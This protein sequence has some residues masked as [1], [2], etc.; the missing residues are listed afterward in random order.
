MK[1]GMIIFV[2]LFL[3]FSVFLGTSQ[4]ASKEFIVGCNL[5]LSGPAASI[6][7]GVQRAMDHAVEVINKDGF[8]VQGEKYTL[9]PIYY[10]NKY[11]PAEAVLNLEKMLSSGI[12]FIHSMGSGVTVPLVEK[13]TAAKVF[14][15]A[16]CSGS[17][18]L[19]NPKYPY[20]FR[21]V[22]TNEAAFA[23][24]PWLAKAYPQVKKV[25]HANPSDEAGFTESE[26]RVKCAK[27]SGFE[28]VANEYFKRGATD[29]YPAATRLVATKPDLIDFGGTAG[30]DQGLL[31][32]AL[33]EVGYKGVLVVSYTDPAAF[34]QVVGRDGAEGVIL[35]N[36]VTEPTNPKQQE[37]ND[38]YVKKYG[39]PVVGIFYDNW[40]P[41][42]ML[43]EAVKKANSFDPI[44]VA[45]T[46]RFI[47]WDSIFGPMTIGMESLYGIKSSACRPLPMGVIKQGKPTHLATVP[48]P[49]DETIKKL[50]AN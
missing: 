40:D 16:G 32:K 36:T 48:W 29:F 2:G 26:T 19:T 21:V 10:D 12:K 42:F 43:I 3:V 18:H 20:T 28:N 8:M 46:F 31:A 30:R 13:T 11:I 1:K 14:M 44:K 25:A 27:N 22:P 47:Q 38:W 7:I 39:P 6:G 5:A 49:S 33:R 15:M 34:V 24:Y 9:K 50:S 23:M 37:L 4:A 45:E 41:P 35:P 17:H